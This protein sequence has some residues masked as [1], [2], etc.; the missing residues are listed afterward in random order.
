MTDRIRQ[1]LLRNLSSRMDLL[2]K[3]IDLRWLRVNEE[4]RELRARIARLEKS[5]TH[6]AKRVDALEGRGKK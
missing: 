4:L 2:D 1:T 5:H 6:Y 3:L